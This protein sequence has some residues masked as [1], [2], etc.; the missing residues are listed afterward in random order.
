MVTLIKPPK[1]YY[2]L[3]LSLPPILDLTPVSAST[4]KTSPPLAAP[5]S[6]GNSNAGPD[7]VRIHD[8]EDQL[9]ICLD[10]GNTWSA[11]SWLVLQK[12]C[13]I[14]EPNSLIRWE[15][16]G[17]QSP[18]IPSSVLYDSKTLKPLAFGKPAEE[19][20]TQVRGSVLVRN[21]KLC[22]HPKHMRTDTSTP[23]GDHS[24]NMPR[25][26]QG[27]PALRVYA[28]F[29]EFLL[30]EVKYGMC[31]LQGGRDDQWNHLI[32]Q[33]HFILGA[34]NGW[35]L[36][37][38]GPILEVFKSIS[39]YRST[40]RVTMISEAEASLFYVE[41][42]ARGQDKLLPIKVGKARNKS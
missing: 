32:G 15:H 11:A 35:D 24:F 28:D 23:N 14:K 42:L 10:I 37:E 31:S 17:I 3:S 36:K 8:G 18:K 19:M 2:L 21:F 9:V 20:Q 34:P 6:T 13:P 22:L 1:H 16:W 41:H 25:L 30:G 40:A 26:P 5:I 4:A 7:A 33:A 38:K 12:G 39:H 29:L 27:L